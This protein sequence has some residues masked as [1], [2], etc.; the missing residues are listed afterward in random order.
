[1]T[2]ENPESSSFPT[3]A[4]AK[5]SSQPK[6]LNLDEVDLTRDGV[7]GD[8]VV[9]KGRSSTFVSKRPTAGDDR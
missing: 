2:R 7:Q 5:P 6:S 9:S 1:M 3:P 4:I 8:V